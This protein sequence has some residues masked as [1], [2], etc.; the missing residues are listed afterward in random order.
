MTDTATPAEVRPGLTRR[1]FP[2]TVRIA[3]PR[4]WGRRSLALVV[5]LVMVAVILPLAGSASAQSATPTP[6][7]G[8]LSTP[9]ANPDCSTVSPAKA[10]AVESANSA[11]RYRAEEQLVGKGANEAVGQTNAV[12]GTIY[13]DQSGMPLACSRIDADLR[14]LKSDEARRDNFLYN[15]T[16]ETQQYPLATFILTSV[17]GLNQPLG[18]TEVTFTL[19]GDLTIHGVSK[20]VSWTATAKLDGGTI[21]GHAATTFKMEDFNIEPP[22]VGPVLSLSDVVKLEVDLTAIPAT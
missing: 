18:A 6:T 2:L 3:R 17:Q 10:Y 20:S 14:T 4:R 22:K 21:T 1:R 19:I 12:I 5:P 8:V 16:L 7:P 9:A 11:V 13:F 15:N